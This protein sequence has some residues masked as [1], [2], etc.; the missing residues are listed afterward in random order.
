MRERG[1]KGEQEPEREQAITRAPHEVGG[2]VRKWVGLVSFSCLSAF[3][4]RQQWRWWRLGLLQASKLHGGLTCD[5]VAKNSKQA[6]ARGGG[7]AQLKNKKFCS[8]SYGMEAMSA[9]M[10]FSGGLAAA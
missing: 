9:V 6:E 10:A 4:Q 7:E 5:Y 8:G 1:R 2:S 3:E